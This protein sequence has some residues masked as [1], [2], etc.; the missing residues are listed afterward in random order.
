[1]NAERKISNSTSLKV[2]GYVRLSR[3]DDKKN[4]V[5]IENQ[6]MIINKFALE[7]GWV[8]DSWYEDDG[9]S[10][11][12]FKRPDFMKLMEDLDQTI[13]IVITKDL[14]RLGRHNAKVLLLLDDIKE[15]GKR[16]IVIDDDYDTLED[17]DD[18]IGIKTWYNER[19]VK[20]T[21]KKVKRVISA[22]QNEGNLLV[23]VPFGYQRD[24][25]DKLKI[26]IVEE[27][28]TYIRNIFELYLQGYGYRKIAVMLSEQGI[29][30]PSMIMQKR[31]LSEGKI[32]K[33]RVTREWSD[34][35]VS[36]IL[37]ND[38][39]IGNLRLHKRARTI[40]NGMDHR[41]KK[42]NQILFNENHEA[43]IE[44]PTFE[45]VQDIMRKRVR[46]N[47]R[48]QSEEGNIFGGCLFCKDCGGRLTPILRKNNTNR[49]YYICNTYNSKGKRYCGY[50]HL[51]NETTLINDVTKYISLCRNTLSEIIKT[52]DMKDFVQEIETVELKRNKIKELIH[53]NKKQLKIMISQKVKDISDGAD[54]AI[55]NDAYESLQGEILAK[56]H[57][58]EQQLKELEETSLDN[59]NIQAK[60]KTALQVVDE[61]IKKGSLNR[62]DVE[63]LIEKIIVDKDGMPEIELKYGLSGLINYSP[64]EELNKYEN[65]II[66]ATMK[67]IK[68]E[69]RT[70]TSAKYL[71]AELTKQGFKKSKKSVLPY[72]AIMIEKGIVEATE[73]KLK[74]YNIVAAKDAISE[75]IDI[76]MESMTTWRYA[77][78]GT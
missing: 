53:D 72:I 27:E 25:K 16:L 77:G 39:Y 17:E 30:T 71:S 60:L 6:K 70:Y 45:L 36:N 38:F 23:G 49:K 4:Y 33:R 68:E 62:K 47:Y 48:G 51:I 12:S 18:T 1:M 2:A 50:A 10:G 58:Y 63:I 24:K 46:T 31:N 26:Q 28:A 40:I 14:S 3:D 69:E 7:Q 41:I 61:I 9:F 78:N 13:D 57:G 54:L 22:L 56:I 64:L 75:M 15:R 29:P 19:Y 32:S 43:I 37:K 8:I 20:D 73:D 11:Y 67:L 21:S 59:S 76:Y 74:P 35:M 66:L 65:E 52:Y 34:G 44:E 42:E 55:I 5:S